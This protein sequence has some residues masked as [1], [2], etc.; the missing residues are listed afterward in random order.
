MVLGTRQEPRWINTVK[1]LQNRN[2]GV[3]IGLL[4]SDK[5]G[6][7]NTCKMVELVSSFKMLS[8]LATDGDTNSAIAW[9]YLACPFPFPCQLLPHWEHVLL[10]STHSVISPHCP[11]PN[12]LLRLM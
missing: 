8:V 10:A 1:A 3:A 9:V 5:G 12:T 11:T 7:I 6:T 4:A 2:A